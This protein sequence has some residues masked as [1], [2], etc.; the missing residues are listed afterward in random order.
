[1]NELHDGRPGRWD[2]SL[3]LLDGPKQ[4]AKS[5][6]FMRFDEEDIKVVIR[7]EKMEGFKGICMKY[8]KSQ[9]PC[10]TAWRNFLQGDYVLGLEPGTVYPENREISLQ[11]DRMVKLHPMEEMK[12]EI[13][14]GI[15]K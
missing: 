5:T 2:E 1:V 11:K 9:L 15:E 14:F 6:L 12:L 7:N 4:K 13:E 8:K 3:S 10:F